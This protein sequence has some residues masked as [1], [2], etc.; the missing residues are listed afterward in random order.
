MQCFEIMRK[1]SVAFATKG[2]RP[3]IATDLFRW[4]RQAHRF[5]WVLRIS[6]SQDILG[7]YKKMLSALHPSPD[8]PRWWQSF[9]HCQGKSLDLAFRRGQELRT[10]QYRVR[11]RVPSYS[12][13]L[14]LSSFFPPENFFAINKQTNSNLLIDSKNAF[15]C[16]TYLEKKKDLKLG[17]F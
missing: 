7:T 12:F 17:L 1:P 9:E 11:G 10:E 15:K 4:A 8:G 16:T 5:S 2:F 6:C 13:Y 3:V 14:K